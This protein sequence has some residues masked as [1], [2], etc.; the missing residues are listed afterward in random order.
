MEYLTDNLDTE[1]LVNLFEKAEADLI[2]YKNSVCWA[3]IE[4][5]AFDVIHED[6]QRIE[7]EEAKIAE[8]MTANV[9]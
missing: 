2:V 5:L 1:F 6:D 3:F 7:D 9:Y 4:Y 8:Y